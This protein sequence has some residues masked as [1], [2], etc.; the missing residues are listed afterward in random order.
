MMFSKGETVMVRGMVFTV[1]RPLGMGMTAEVYL[2]RD[3]AGQ[4]WAL[5]HL[6]QG[7]SPQIRE[8]LHREM[9]NL[10]RLESAWERAQQDESP[11]G[12]LARQ[13][14]FPAPRFRIGDEQAIVMEYISG[15]PA[16][17]RFREWREAGEATVLEE[18]GLALALQLGVLLW[19]LHE[20]A[21]RCYSD[22]K[23]DNLFLLDTAKQHGVSRFPLALK[24]VDWSVLNERNE[25]WVRRDLFLATLI[26][27]RLLTGETL[28]TQHLQVTVSIGR[29]PLFNGLSLGLQRFFRKA[30]SP[31][32]SVRYQTAREWTD[33]LFKYKQ[34]WDFSD[35]NCQHHLT[36]EYQRVRDMVVRL[37]RLEIVPSTAEE[38]RQQAQTVLEFIEAYDIARRRDIEVPSE[39]VSVYEEY[40]EV[41]HPLKI[42]ERAFRGL[43]FD[44]A[45]EQFERG[46]ALFPEEKFIYSHWWIAAD[47]AQHIDADAFRKY[48]EEILAG[49]QALTE[50][51]WGVARE[52]LLPVVHYLIGQMLSE[53]E[54]RRFV[55]N[56]YTI[57]A[58]WYGRD[59]PETLHNGL[60]WLFLETLAV[61]RLREAEQALQW[62]E[63]KKAQ[64]A[65]DEARYLL[66]WLPKD[67]RFAWA[68]DESRAAKIAEQAQQKREEAYRFQE[69]ERKYQIALEERNWQELA[70]AL[71]ELWEDPQRRN[72]TRQRWIEAITHAWETAT[73]EDVMTLVDGLAV[74]LGSVKEQEP[75][76]MAF[77]AQKV[78]FPL[79]K[80]RYLRMETFAT[81][82]WKEARK[83]WEGLVQSVRNMP[84]I[85]KHGLGPI[86]EEILAWASQ[87]ET[88]LLK[89]AKANGLVYADIPLTQ[90]LPVLEFLSFILVLPQQDEWIQKAIAKLETILHEKW[91]QNLAALV[92]NEKWEQL[93]TCL[94]EASKLY[95]ADIWGP[96]YRSGLQ[97]VLASFLQVIN[98][99]LK[100]WDALHPLLQTYPERF[101]V[102]FPLL[103]SE[104]RAL[105]RFLEK[106]KPLL[107]EPSL[108]TRWQNLQNHLAALARALPDPPLQEHVRSL[109]AA[110]NRFADSILHGEATTNGFQALRWVA[111]LRALGEHQIP[112][113]Q[114]YSALRTYFVHVVQ[115]SGKGK[116]ELAQLQDWLLTHYLTKES[117]E[118]LISRL[119]AL[120]PQGEWAQLYV[121]ATYLLRGPLV[122][123]FSQEQ[124]KQLEALR[125]QA[126]NALSFLAWTRQWRR[127]LA[128]SPP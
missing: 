49:V 74:A 76:E 40:V 80:L 13:M 103:R 37:R 70:A 19:A 29:A 82:A 83:M 46:L 79:L 86:R 81:E 38:A 9:E 102:L 71:R 24:V 94:G 95:P 111:E 39:W 78:L 112:D 1:E 110:L 106:T 52:K 23:M 125:Q 109:W 16:E 67:S 99:E 55:N 89:E 51:Q 2:V 53:E 128:A 28:P 116:D 31:F 14:V 7:A 20:K 6:R 21:N 43:S 30:L 3:E 98:D 25:D 42:G 65:A 121:E 33:S 5:K 115:A 60:F 68:L 36:Q 34:Y 64:E 123:F 91:K 104:L 126:Y 124:R 97:E 108:R 50:Y 120:V 85:Q 54:Q 59:L 117:I 96:I 66:R 17:H 44:L 12:Q 105:Q 8:L 88:V 127:R 62:G 119:E 118:R 93:Q 101:A 73:L 41:L 47:G 87:F 84:Y 90:W 35:E 69:S 15:V 75:R 107:V 122:E 114:E 11:L 72:T 45:K 27:Y 57:L 92:A 48:R 58:R 61:Q 77:L 63:Y 22:M 56:P 4:Y 18:Q 113:G 100:H 32:L 26:L 10:R